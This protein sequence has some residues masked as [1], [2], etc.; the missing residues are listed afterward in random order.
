MY[1]YNRLPLYIIK[2]KVDAL[3]QK[4]KKDED[5]YESD[6]IDD[7]DE[8]EPV[9]DSDDDEDYNPKKEKNDDD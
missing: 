3:R 9:D 4:K 1:W 2:F 6:F 7:S 5:V 8:F